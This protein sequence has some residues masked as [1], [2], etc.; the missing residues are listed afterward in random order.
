MGFIMVSEKILVNSPLGIHLRP[1]GAMCDKAIKFKSKIYFSYGE[2]KVANAKSVISILASGVK[3]GTQIELTAG[4]E[5]EENA[6]KT[7]S[8]AFKLAL[9][10]D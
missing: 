2:G 5:D 7:V 4:G 1:A 3:C 9:K 8:E 10:E 6:L